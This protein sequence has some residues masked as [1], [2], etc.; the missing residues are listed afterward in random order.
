MARIHGSL[1]R[2]PTRTTL[3]VL[4]GVSTDGR[5]SL[6]FTATVVSGGAAAARGVPSASGTALAVAIEAG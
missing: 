4:V 1:K 3:I 2:S 5:S 6:R